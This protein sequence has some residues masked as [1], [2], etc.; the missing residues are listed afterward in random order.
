MLDCFAALAMTNPSLRAQRSNPVPQDG[1]SE[2]KPDMAAP[3]TMA[4]FV[5]DFN[6]FCVGFRKI[7]QT[8]A[9]YG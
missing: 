3:N 5:C 2:A 9:G 4:G 7:N 8:H 6:V 1:R